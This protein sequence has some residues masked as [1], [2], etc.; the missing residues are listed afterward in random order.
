MTAPH[1]PTGA[2]NPGPTVRERGLAKMAEVYGFDFADG[3]DALFALTADHLFAG[4]WSRP[5]LSV[6]DRRLLLLGALTAGG[7]PDVA[8]IQVSAALHNGECTGEQLHAIAR[9]LGTQ[10]GPAQGEALDE[11]V[12]AALGR[13]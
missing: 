4:I 2:E 11:V 6:R 5:G 1:P 8:S 13:A 10:L 9:F 3:T 7:L 12:T